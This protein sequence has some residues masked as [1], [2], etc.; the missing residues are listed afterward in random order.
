MCR[1]SKSFLTLFNINI[2]TPKLNPVNAVLGDLN[3]LFLDDKV[4]E[5]R[6]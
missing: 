1:S 2:I 3:P 6:K 5:V 4:Y